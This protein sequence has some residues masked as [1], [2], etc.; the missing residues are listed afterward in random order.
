MAVFVGTK[1][2]SIASVDKMSP[3]AFADISRHFCLKLVIVVPSSGLKSVDG[4]GDST[5]PYPVE[6]KVRDD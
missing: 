3:S 1:T 6:S 4:V 2:A 5:Q